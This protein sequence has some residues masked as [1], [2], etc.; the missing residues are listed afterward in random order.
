[1]IVKNL[2][3]NITKCTFLT[4]E[5]EWCD[6]RISRQGWTYSDKYFSKILKTSRPTFT[7]ELAQALYLINWLSPCIPHLAFIRD[8]FSPV[9]KLNT[10]MRELKKDSEAI[11]WTSALDQA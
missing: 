8:V 7:H 2:R 4:S 6:R 10:T 9:V 5:D 1:M 11:L 3:L